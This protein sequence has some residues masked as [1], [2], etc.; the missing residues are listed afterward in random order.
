[1]DDSG[2]EPVDAGL[3]ALSRADWEGAQ[4]RFET[5][6]ART[7]S[8]EARVGL[9]EA[10]WWQGQ[11]PA[12]VHHRQSA[13][14]VLRRRVDPV[15]AA[16]V[17]LWLSVA[18]KAGYGNQAA[19]AGWLA[20]A[21]RLL[22]ENKP[23]PIMGWLYL[24]ASGAEGPTVGE[25]L[26]EKALRIALRFADI[27]LELAALSQIGVYQVI[28]GRVEQGMGHLDEALAAALGDEA[29]APSTVVIVSCHMLLACRQTGDHHRSVQWCAASERF[30]SRYG[31]PYLF[32]YCRAA[33]GAVLFAMGRWEAA[34]A[35]LEVACRASESCYPAIHVQ[36][37]ATLAELRVNQGRLED[38]QA[39]LNL[40]DGQAATTRASARLG[41]AR[42]KFVEVCSS[43]QCRLGQ[44]DGQCAE[45]SSLLD[46]LVEVHLAQGQLLEAGEAA[47]RLQTYAA[48]TGLDS[49]IARA[50]LAA[51]RVAAASGDGEKALWYLQAAV[52]GFTSVE[53]PMER[54]R[55]GLD[56]AQLLSHHAPEAALEEAYQ[57]LARF[58]RLGA[59][60]QADVVAALIRR[61]GGSA[62][63]GPK[64]RAGLTRREGDVLRL[65]GVGLSN[66]EIAARLYISRKTV[67]HHVSHVLA[68]LNLRSRSQAAAY[69]VERPLAEGV[70]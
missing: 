70:K 5:A 26:A 39:L 12:A 9:S 59:N 37:L 22:K 34:E 65:L 69:L 61:L 68:K 6:V 57:A 35:E 2:N 54:A 40:V 10:L 32:A 43:L 33:Y 64:G 31:C 46:L 52:D 51:G 38:A 28:L 8:A 30:M 60:W 67:E 66:P 20:R 47:D 27:D 42:G 18:Y 13:Y 55:A 11:F 48:R 17:A 45:S 23:S 49:D 3:T 36:V 58:E 44:L 24:T 21:E 62:R 4:A 15:A 41:M 7:G 63:T 19:S 14:A 16:Q 56:L 1:M 29:T 50:R 25:Q 53:L